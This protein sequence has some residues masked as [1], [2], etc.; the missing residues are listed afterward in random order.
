M[1]QGHLQKLLE[2]AKGAYCEADRLYVG[3][4]QLDY[5]R[6][7]L[8]ADAEAEFEAAGYD[9][10]DGWERNPELAAAI[11]MR[12]HELKEKS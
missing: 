10:P 7:D 6:G 9:P 4:G 3:R 1:A 11:T 5:P 12:A 8:Y 2:D